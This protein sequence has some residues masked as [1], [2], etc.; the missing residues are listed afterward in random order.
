MRQTKAKL[1]TVSLASTL[2]LVA[3]GGGSDASIGGT[4]S[5][6]GSGLSLTL[7]N[8]NADYLTMAGNQ[9]FTFAKPI[10]SNSSYDVTVL[11]QPI[12]QTCSVANGSGTVDSF[13]DAVSNIAVSCGYSSSVGGIVTG[14]NAGTS[15][16]LST[17]GAL[18]PIAANGLFAFP[19][20]L[21]PGSTYNV[22]VTT[23]PLGQTCSVSNPNGTIIANVMSS[24]VVN[25]I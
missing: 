17:N 6:L 19:G 8:N 15:V 11:T 14:L 4:I 3:C 12:G 10:A 13:G 1:L 23:Q 21:P 5:G 22:A 16:T 25:C 7:Q 9:S 2:L 24:V 20:M 18:L